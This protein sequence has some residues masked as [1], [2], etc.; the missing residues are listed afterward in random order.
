MLLGVVVVVLGC[1]GGGRRWVVVLL[2]LVGGCVARRGCI[3]G[4]GRG[5]D[6]LIDGLPK[7]W[8]A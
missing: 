3:M 8:R 5:I 7:G 6:S 1:M 2:V 4:K